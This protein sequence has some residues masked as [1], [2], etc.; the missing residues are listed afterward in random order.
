MMIAAVLRFIE[1]NI[2]GKHIGAKELLNPQ[3]KENHDNGDPRSDR[4]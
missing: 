3:T 1:S 4:K 2:V